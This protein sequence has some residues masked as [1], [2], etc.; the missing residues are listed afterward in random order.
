MPNSLSTLSSNPADVDT[1]V[2]LTE[3]PPRPLPLSEQAYRN[4]RRDILN[5]TLRPDVPLRFEALKERYGYS[6]SPLREA[7]AR[8]QAERLVKA[9]ALRGYRVAEVSL[10]EMWD[11]IETRVL[12]ETAA[13]RA[14]IEHG[15]A[16]WEER[17]ELTFH[18][19]ERS[20]SRLAAREKPVDEAAIEAL[21][22]RHRGFHEALVSAAP[23]RWLRELSGILYVQTERYRRPLLV[24]RWQNADG[25]AGVQGEHRALRDAAL[26]RNAEVAANLLAA[27]LRS[28][29]DYIER[30]GDLS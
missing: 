2:S 30:R 13:L 3:V 27:H 6:F 16:N 25:R 29:G 5:G 19:L 7:L 12:L 28:T 10:T 23:S 20:A 15:D 4:L 14:A 8:L 18:A 26:A 9:T 17:I 22:E 1:P 11:A 24:Q 21:E